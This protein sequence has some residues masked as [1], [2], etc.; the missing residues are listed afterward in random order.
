MIVYTNVELTEVDG[1]RL[2]F[3][4]EANDGVDLISKGWHQRYVIDKKDFDDRV[5]KKLSRS[6]PI[7]K[8]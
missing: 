2:T 6:I 3:S 7:N 8:V 4:V 1:R 5:S